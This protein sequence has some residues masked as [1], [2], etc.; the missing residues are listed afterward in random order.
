ML[1]AGTDRNRM[2]VGGWKNVEV[3]R[4]ACIFGGAEAV[5]KVAVV[6]N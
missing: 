1:L 4:R 5:G 2:K 3:Q 6:C